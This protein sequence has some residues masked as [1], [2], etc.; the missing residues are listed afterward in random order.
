MQQQ[1]THLSFNCW[2]CQKRC[3]W[4]ER[5]TIRYD[6]FTALYWTW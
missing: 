6:Y 3:D 5:K 1:V 4:T 2:S